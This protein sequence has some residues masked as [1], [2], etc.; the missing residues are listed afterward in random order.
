MH[1]FDVIFQVPFVESCEGAL[2]TREVC[3]FLVSLHSV[4]NRFDMGPQVALVCSFE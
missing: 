3:G 2:V 4:M 1:N